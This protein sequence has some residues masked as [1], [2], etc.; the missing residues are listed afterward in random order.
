MIGRIG[1]VLALIAVPALA[2]PTVFVTSAETVRSNR[3]FSDATEVNGILYLS[4]QTGVPPGADK[5]VAGG[6]AAETRQIMAN[7]GAVLAKRGLGHDDLFKCT[8]MLADMAQWD[9]FNRVY[10]TY[11]TPGRLPSRSAM[12][13]NGLARGAAVE[14]ECWA[15]TAR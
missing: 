14:L 1:L 8:V 13:V 10:I 9:A 2:G 4:G 6:L 5:V 7:I 12:G 3:P 11:F 15:N